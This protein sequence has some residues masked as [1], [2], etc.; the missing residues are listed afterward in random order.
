V[1]FADPFKLL[2]LLLALLKDEFTL[3]LFVATCEIPVCMI[4]VTKININDEYKI[5]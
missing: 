3:L 4:K 1:I 5:Y 2:A